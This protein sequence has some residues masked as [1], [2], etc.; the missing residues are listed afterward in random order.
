[1]LRHLAVAALALALAAPARS[2]TPSDSYETVFGEVKDLAPRADRVATVHGL[3]LR[4]DVM[5]LRLESGS[6]SLLT[7][8]S[9][10]SIGVV[11][12]G[13]GSVSFVPPLAVERANLR[14][15]LGDSTVSGP[16][17]RAV[18]LFTDSTLAEL[19]R[20][21]TFAAGT[22][23]EDAGGAV[24]D[25]LDYLVEGRD[26]YVDPTLMAG[27]LNGTANGF[28]GAYVKR[29]RGEGVLI[30]IDPTQAEEVL[31]FR[32]GRL[33][34]QR[35]ETVCEFQRAE[36]LR[37]GVAVK[38]EQ[39]EPLEVDAYGIDATI[40]GNYKFSAKTTL[41]A[42]GRRD[43]QRWIPFLLYSELDV[44]S[45]A[46]ENGTPLTFFRADH[47]APLWV[48]LA[49]PMGPGDVR[50][51]RIAYHGSLIGFGS[52]IEQFL[53]PWWDPSRRDMPAMLDNW[54]F[55]KSTSTWY[56]RYSF[57]QPAAM[58]MTFHTPKA[59]K[60]ASIGR[61]A[62]SR[63]EGNVV[64]THWLTDMPTNQVSF[65]IG[66]FDEFEIKDPRIPP[67]TVQI[68]AD[69]HRYIH[70]FI[71]QARNPQEQVGADVANSLAFF[72][73]VFGPP[74]FEHYYA[75]EIPYFHGQAFP[76]MIHLSWATYMSLSTTGAD[77]SFRAHEMAHQWWGIAVEPAS[78]RDVWLAEGFAEFAGLWYMQ[79]ILHDN[80]KYFKQ[81]RESRQD[82]RRQRDKAVPIVL[83]TRAAESW[84][85]HY[86]LVVY[87]KGAWV[88]QM[89]RNMMLNLRT[90][91]EDPFKAMMHDFYQSY[92]GK[93]AST[94][95]FQRVVERHVGQPM[96]WF[97]QEWVYGTSVPTYTLSWQAEPQPDGKYTL[98]LRVRQAEVPDDFTMLVPLLIEFADGQ[99][100]VRVRVKGPVSE[101]SLTLPAEPKAVTLNP[102][103]SVLAEVKTEAWQP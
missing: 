69:A 42:T 13:E 76:G 62:E 53:P 39:P 33:L 34:G 47:A 5:E 97:F 18:L 86:G 41:R 45:V 51:L 49:Q 19:E 27:L 82:I 3:V 64:T 88:L 1:V 56:P 58:D 96:D 24:H 4:R 60:F 40:D 9:G 98:R 12:V 91:D 73:Q 43:P 95:D 46:D 87:Q 57:E 37:A 92:R 35:V 25:A 61:L 63:T 22:P 77:E 102:L 71:P 8:V 23:A 6:L 52:T 30:E 17:T 44:D 11:F 36:D 10:R 2:Q 59:Y 85:G 99:A 75:T 48:R 65:N 31:L 66:P 32:R 80:D 78:Y 93:R 89:L 38:T 94:E 101:V 81:L 26:R 15:V 50:G 90:M 72:T 54:A 21:L 55:I 83:G 29:I 20:S 84:S 103:E 28:F 7:P 68:N 16:I 67:V 100:L 70:R 14:R 74:M 79:I